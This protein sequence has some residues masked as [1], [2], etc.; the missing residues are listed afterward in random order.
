MDAR[1][2]RVSERITASTSWRVFV[3]AVLVIVFGGLAM[4]Q[5]Y[6][7][8]RGDAVPRFRSDVVRLQTNR[9][10][11]M[12][13]AASMAPGDTISSTIRIGSDGGPDEIRLYG[14]TQGAVFARHLELEVSRGSLRIYVGTL[15]D[16][17]DS[18]ETGVV[19]PP[20]QAVSGGDTYRFAVTLAR[21]GGWFPSHG[22][23]QTF[24]W[25]AREA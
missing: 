24:T 7:A 19:L 20:I 17:P 23:Q 9:T 4:S 1:V 25:E 13:D 14:S 16:F 22:T 18:Y 21:G 8:L 2:L 15:A 12:F 11:A 3:T 6:A 5:A 10:N